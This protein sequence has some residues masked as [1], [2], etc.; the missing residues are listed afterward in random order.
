MRSPSPSMTRRAN[1]RPCIW[2]TNAG[3]WFARA[4]TS[5]ISAIGKMDSV[6]KSPMARARR[7]PAWAARS[8]VSGAVFG[9]CSIESIGVNTGQPTWSSLP[10]IQFDMAV[11]S[12]PAL[13]LTAANNIEIP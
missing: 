1:S 3:L 10:R 12:Q 2:A 6:R 11:T 4:A 5:R 8:Q 13:P 7:L 9:R